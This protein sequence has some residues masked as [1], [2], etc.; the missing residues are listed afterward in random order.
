MSGLAWPESCPPPRRGRSARRRWSSMYPRSRRA[1]PRSRRRR[2]R[3]DD[4]RGDVSLSMLLFV[5]SMSDVPGPER[6]HPPAARGREHSRTRPH[7]MSI[8]AASRGA[9]ARVVLAELDEIRESRE[10][11]APKAAVRDR[12]RA[13][14]V[15]R[16]PSPGL[17][18]LPLLAVELHHAG[19][20]TI[21]L[22]SRAAGER[23]ATARGRDAVVPLA[24]RLT[25]EVLDARRR[26]RD[27][28]V[29]R[30]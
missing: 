28:Q 14:R 22:E 20:H 12:E 19:E 11:E 30:E 23:D 5:A 6:S 4:R 7:C 18:G 24:V 3:R 1:H 2:K 8:H 17:R 27:E 26:L 9:D 21:D 29:V 13:R 15:E 10:H 25:L 16:A